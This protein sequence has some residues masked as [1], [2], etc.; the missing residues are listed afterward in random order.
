MAEPIHRR[1]HPK[2]YTRQNNNTVSK[3]EFETTKTFKRILSQA[4]ARI[5]TIMNEQGVEYGVRLLQLLITPNMRCQLDKLQP[6]ITSIIQ[7][8]QDTFESTEPWPTSYKMNCKT[9]LIVLMLI[10]IKLR[11]QLSNNQVSCPCSTYTSLYEF[12]PYLLHPRL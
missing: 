10:I 1:I 11:A 2:G 12:S 3:C 4:I 7:F 9:I 6:L 5:V 8:Q